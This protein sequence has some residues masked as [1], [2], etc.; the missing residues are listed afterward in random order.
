MSVDEFSSKHPDNQHC[1]RSSRLISL[2]CSD[3]MYAQVERLL[4]KGWRH[5]DKAT[6]EIRGVFKI[7]SSDESLK[8]YTDYKSQVHAFNLLS[9]FKKGANEQLCFHGTRR[10]NA[11]YAVSS[12]APMMSANAETYIRSKDSEMESIPLVALPRQMTTLQSDD[13]AAGTPI[14]TCGFFSSIV[15]L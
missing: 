7:L 13:Q 5:S 6:P 15:S 1:Q 2:E 3:P 11:Q 4:L 14:E 10:L 9:R 12:E 8:A